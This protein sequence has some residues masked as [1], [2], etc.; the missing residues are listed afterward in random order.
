LVAT[1]IHVVLNW[2]PLLGYMRRKAGEFLSLR[3]ELVV[4]FTTVTV[5]VTLALGHVLVAQY[6]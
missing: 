6:H 2:R 5:L 1:V 3:R 4:A